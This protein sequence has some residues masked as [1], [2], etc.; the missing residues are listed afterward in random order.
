MELNTHR[1]MASPQATGVE[2]FE[3]E[4][5]GMVTRYL[6][7]HQESPEPLAARRERPSPR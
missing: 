5:V 4:L 3:H 7:G 2:R 1:I 6:A